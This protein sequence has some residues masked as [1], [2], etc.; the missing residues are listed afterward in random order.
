M[1]EEKVLDGVSFAIGYTKGK[2]SASG[3]ELNIAYG[4]TPPEDT[5]KLWA[6]TSEPNGV[7][8]S[9]LDG[10]GNI[11]GITYKGV[12]AN[13]SA[14]L[15]YGYACVVGRKIY[16]FGGSLNGNMTT[17]STSS[18]IRCFD[19]ESL[20]MEDSGMGYS[21]THVCVCSVGTSIYYFGG[22]YYSTNS[23]VSSNGYCY[24]TISKTT[25]SIQGMGY[26][27]GGFA[28]SFGKYIYVFGGTVSPGQYT[29]SGKP[30][31]KI[32]R[33][34]TTTG[35]YVELTA[36]L[37]ASSMM[38]RGT[39]VGS[40]VYLCLVTGTVL[41]YFDV[42]TE[43]VT[44]ITEIN[45]MKCQLASVGT[46]VYFFGED[47]YMQ[48]I[49]RLDDE[50]RDAEE[51]DWGIPDKRRLSSVVAVGRNI[52][53]TGGQG[54][55][56]NYLSTIDFI[57]GELIPVAVPSGVLH[58]IPS[59]EKNYFKLVNAENVE[60]EIGV[61]AVCRGNSDGMSEDVNASLYQN[62]EWATI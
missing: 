32:W 39:V 30:S 37:P 49:Y 38:V 6:K 10:Y 54:E 55:S 51:L 29:S 5:S 4:D 44:E 41:C 59:L 1:K 28:A 23:M 48:R 25:A 46:S 40:R 33:Y 42:E 31:N 52:Y 19:T 27:Y 43:E 17:S 16:T 2:Q 18:K 13:L 60:V 22:M 8:V 47:D 57:S 34:D 12:V 35:S 56:G 58:I 53:A 20:A 24:D 61:E 9:R 15:N 21:A 50:T 3:A 36:T 7:V 62:G 45:S 14:A 11:G 26:R